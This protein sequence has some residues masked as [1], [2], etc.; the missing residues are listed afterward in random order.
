MSSI[1]HSDTRGPAI[2]SEK[3]SSRHHVAPGFESDAALVSSATN[4]SLARLARATFRLRRTGSREIGRCPT[5]AC[6]KLWGIELDALRSVLVRCRWLLSGKSRSVAPSLRP[7]VRYQL[8]MVADTPRFILPEVAVRIAPVT[9][10]ARYWLEID[11]AKT[12]ALFGRY[13]GTNPHFWVPFWSDSD[14]NE[15]RAARS[16][17]GWVF[18]LA[19]NVLDAGLDLTSRSRGFPIRGTWRDRSPGS[20]SGRFFIHEPGA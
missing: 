6:T 18:D 20:Q 5:H 17:S 13:G 14:V 4:S 9:D 3:I 10:T 2:D 16:D 11:S 15:F 7:G 1:S 12:N 19:P 8:T